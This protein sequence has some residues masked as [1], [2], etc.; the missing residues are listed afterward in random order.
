MFSKQSPDGMQITVLM[1]VDDLFITSP[2]IY[3]HARFEKCLR[4]KYNE[5]NVFPGKVVDYIGM[6][7]DFIVP[8]Q[9]SITMDNCERFILPS[10]GC[11]R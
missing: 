3:N 2:G 4:D 9:V 5:V 1:H 8:G 10:W 7:F 6:T 11:G